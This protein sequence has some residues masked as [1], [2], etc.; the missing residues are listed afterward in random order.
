MAL[1]LFFCTFTPN[2]ERKDYYAILGVSKDASEE[3]IKKKYRSEAMKWHPDRWATGTD[4]EKKAAEA[5]F[6]DLSEA[7][8]VLSDPNKRA[9][10]DNPNS[11]FVFEGN[12][13]PMDIF[14]HMQEMHG[15]GGDFFDGFPGFGRQRARKGENIEAE[16]RITISEAYN[17]CK[18]E[19]MIPKKKPCSHCH[20]TGFEDGHNHDCPNCQGNGI[21]TQMTKTGQNSFSSF[22]FPCPVC[23][24]TGKDNNAK[25]CTKCGGSGFEFDYSRDVIEVHR[26][27]SDGITLSIQGRGEPIDGGINGDLFVHVIV[28]K[29]D[30]FERPDAVNVIHR[31]SVPFTEALLGFK[32]NFRCIDGTEVT[33]D[34]PELTRDG[35]AFIF[36]GKGMPDLNGRGYGDYAVVIN[37]KLPEK[38]TDKQ[39]EIL[40]HFND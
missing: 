40:K 34:A 36:R 26:G 19:I 30:Y 3:E 8:E 25:K 29:D 20:G 24:G 1:P 4:E 10:Y 27:I 13:D 35:Q 39:R 28:E 11:G 17:G 37:H 33:V 32:K 14:R 9:Q 18:K 38:L 5:K 22:S 7:Y 2:M 23:H 12:I 15:F 21:V 6:K 16:V 31:E